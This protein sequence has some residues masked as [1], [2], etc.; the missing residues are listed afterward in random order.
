MYIIAI[1]KRCSQKNV[2]FIIK[3][4]ERYKESL[5]TLFVIHFH[6][7][8]DRGRALRLA[9]WNLRAWD[10]LHPLLDLL[11]RHRHWT[12]LHRWSS[13]QWERPL[14]RLARKRRWLPETPYVIC[15]CFFIHQIVSTDK[16][17]ALNL[18]QYNAW[19][20]RTVWRSRHRL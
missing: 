3:L 15:F 17:N 13:L 16:A 9:L 4:W 18:P 7:S 19:V 20:N 1:K 2:N 5:T 6:R 8:A 11:E 10:V 14:L 12:A